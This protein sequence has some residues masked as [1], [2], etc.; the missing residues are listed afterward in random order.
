MQIPIVNGI[1]SDT[2]PD[3]RTS[4]PRNLVPVPKQTGINTGYLRPADGIVKLGQGP[5]PDRGGIIWRGVLYR[6]M[7]SKFVSIAED[8][9]L[10][11]IGEVGTGGPVSFDY[12]FDY[13]AIAASFRLFLWNG[14]ELKR[15]T[16]GNLG[17]VLD[18][19][20]ISGYYLTTDGTSLVSTDLND[21]TIVNPL[22]YGSA[23]TDAD[24]IMA[25]DA[26]K[27]EAYAFGRHTVEVFQV[28]GNTNFPF[29][30]V[31]GAQVSRGILGTHCYTFTGETF[32]MLGSGRNE[33]PGVH[34]M[35]PGSTQKISTREIDQ[36]LSQYTET[37]LSTCVMESKS[38]RN[39]IH[40]LLHL[41]N[42][43][44]VFDVS[45]TKMIGEPVWFTFTTSVVGL[46]VYRARGH[47]WAYNRWN[48]GDPVSGLYGYLDSSI[49]SHYGEVNGWEFGTAVLFNESRSAI[50]NELEM[51]CLTGRVEAGNEPVIWTSY[52]HDGQTWSQE[53]PVRCGSMGQRLRRICWRNQGELRNMRM[54]RFRGTSEAHLSISRL[55]AQLE[56]LAV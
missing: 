12:G 18:V 6:V 45:A 3:F 28:T 19:K 55:E 34:M 44:L 37:Q 40:V 42:Q 41:P 53:R 7:G 54:Q 24:P 29:Q 5:G 52:S 33:A 35:M 11:V 14:Q 10:T 2:G 20:W 39:Q 46:G 23:E 49:S 48:V 43:C 30:R 8:G 32:V 15:V 16:N 17:S 21:P 1:Y 4:Y 47:V 36:I 27:N 31:D 22:S 38:V 50:I 13:L 26:V 25:V 51:I 56:P 9:K